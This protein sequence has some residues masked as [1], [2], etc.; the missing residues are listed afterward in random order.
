MNT[1]NGIQNFF[2]VFLH[3]RFCTIRLVITFHASHVTLC[4][5]HPIAFL[6]TNDVSNLDGNVDDK[7]RDDSS[8]EES[9]EV[10]G[11]IATLMGSII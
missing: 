8:D 7:V 1:S 11:D 10:W 2:Q 9:D 4:N 5:M 3:Y 6:T